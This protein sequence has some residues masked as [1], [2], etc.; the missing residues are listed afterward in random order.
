MWYQSVLARAGRS[1]CLLSIFQVHAIVSQHQP[2]P[3]INLQYT[4]DHWNAKSKHN[5]L[6]KEVKGWH[7][8]LYFKCR[9]PIADEHYPYQLCKLLYILSCTPSSFSSEHGYFPTCYVSN[10]LYLQIINIIFHKAGATGT[11]N[12]INLEK[13]PQFEIWWE[14]MTFLNNL[15]A[16]IYHWNKTIAPKTIPAYTFD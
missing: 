12:C 9:P 5:M 15:L 13:L 11:R 3:S 2:Y 14:N 1:Q 16:R 4:R 6:K 8:E 7:N 10:H